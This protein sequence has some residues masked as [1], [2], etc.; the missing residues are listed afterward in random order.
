MAVRGRH[1]GCTSHH[2]EAKGAG[3]PAAGT[4]RPDQCSLARVLLQDL[5]I[6]QANAWVYWQA[7][8][9]SEN[10]NWWGLMQ[11]RAVS[12]TQQCTVRAFAYL[13]E[14]ST[15]DAALTL[16]GCLYDTCRGPTA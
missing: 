2:L 8:E 5:N 3:R 10:G 11:V 7:I 14:S 16:H 15:P 9:N 6:M 4:C 12:T 13:S 1:L